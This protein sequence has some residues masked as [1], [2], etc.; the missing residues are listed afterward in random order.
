MAAARRTSM[1][2]VVLLGLCDPVT[3]YVTGGYLPLAKGLLLGV[4]V[5]LIF[6][7]MVLFTALSLCNTIIALLASLALLSAVGTCSFVTAGVNRTSI[8][9]ALLLGLC[10]PATTYATGGQLLLFMGVCF[11]IMVYLT[12]SLVL[13]STALSLCYSFCLWHWNPICEI[14]NCF[15]H[16]RKAKRL[17]QE[18]SAS[19]MYSSV[20]VC[21]CVGVHVC[22]CVRVCVFMVQSGQHAMCVRVRVYL[23]VCVY[24]PVWAPCKCRHRCGMSCGMLMMCTICFRHMKASIGYRLCAWLK[25]SLHIGGAIR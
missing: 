2:V 5:H 22:A 25:L 20:C 21:V 13:W 4:S 12:V 14:C 24:G 19:R 15:T 7:F 1:S 23:C 10:N 16:R 3:M 9:I 6:S 18:V 17:W 8:S 11:T